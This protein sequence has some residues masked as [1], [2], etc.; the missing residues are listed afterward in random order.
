MSANSTIRTAAL[1]ALS[2]W[3]GTVAAATSCSMAAGNVAFGGYDVF[4]AISL[5][6]DSTVIVTC[7]RDGGPQ[8]ITVSITIGP[9]AYGGTTTSRK[10]KMNGGGDLLGYNL[11]KDAGR[12]VVWGEVSGLDAFTQTLAVPNKSSA[13]LTATIFGRMPAGQEVS[14]GSYSDT[15]FVTVTP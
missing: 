13:Q 9:G 1:V 11:F 3:S 5:D 15:V 4:S 12:T 8:N 10:M 7:S 2:L 6:T 14:K